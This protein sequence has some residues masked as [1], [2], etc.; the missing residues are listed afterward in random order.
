MFY[1]AAAH[2]KYPAL[3]SEFCNRLAL[4]EPIDGFLD[5]KQSCLTLQLTSNPQIFPRVGRCQFTTYLGKLRSSFLATFGRVFIPIWYMTPFYQVLIIYYWE[6]KLFRWVFG[7]LHIP[8]T[9]ID[10]SDKIMKWALRL[11]YRSGQRPVQGLWWALYYRMGN[12][13]DSEKNYLEAWQQ[14]LD[15]PNR[16]C[17]CVGS[18]VLVCSDC[19]SFGHSNIKDAANVVQVDVIKTWPCRKSAS[20]RVGQN[21]Q[22]SVDLSPYTR[23][24][25]LLQLTVLAG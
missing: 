7:K 3:P 23:Y 13:D 15:T 4:E 12:A 9:D 2:N 17:L 19:S 10:Y 25:Y 18:D 22:S 11:M 8:F 20:K 1:T 16:V 5:I 21:R 24:Q 6:M 14:Q